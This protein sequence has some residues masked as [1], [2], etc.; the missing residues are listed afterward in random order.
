ML[1]ACASLAEV[2]AGQWTV[3][4]SILSSRMP[5]LATHDPGKWARKW[6]RKKELVK[7]C[8][9]GVWRCTGLLFEASGRLAWANVTGLAKPRWAWLVV[10]T[11]VCVYVCARARQTD[12]QAACTAEQ[13]PELLL[14]TSIA[15]T[16]ESNSVSS[17]H[18][19]S[20]HSPARPPA[21]PPSTN[22]R[23][24]AQER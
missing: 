19:Q 18:C 10:W 2:Q 13:D 4:P 7:E 1:L 14:A 24:P 22:G 8:S 21:R 11:C 12:R 17:T 20:Y 5:W 15:K 23:L 16:R 9:G 3:Q 6:G